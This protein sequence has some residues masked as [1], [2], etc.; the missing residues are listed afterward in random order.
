MKKKFGF[1]TL[2]MILFIF[3]IVWSR[4]I[5]SLNNFCLGD[6]VL[7]FINLPAYSTYP[8]GNP[9]LHYTVFY[10]FAILILA[11]IVGHKFPEHIFAQ[12]GTILSAICALLFLYTWFVSSM[13][14]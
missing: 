1:G 10:S 3:A 13:T 14:I 5:K 11:V 12:S 2:S 8:N 9:G 4:D 6:A 7:N